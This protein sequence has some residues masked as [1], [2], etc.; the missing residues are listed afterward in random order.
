MFKLYI[1]NNNDSSW[2]M[3]PWLLLETYQGSMLFGFRQP[4]WKKTLS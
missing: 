4:C 1:G 3:R 2:S